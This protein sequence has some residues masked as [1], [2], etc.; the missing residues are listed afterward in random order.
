MHTING[1]T[2]EGKNYSCMFDASE[3]HSNVSPNGQYYFQC[4]VLEA[5]RR[6]DDQPA[7]LIFDMDDKLVYA[8]PMAAFGYYDDTVHELLN[9]LSFLSAEKTI[10][11]IDLFTLPFGTKIKV[12]WHDSRHHKPN[13][14]Y[15]GVIYGHMIGWEDGLSDEQGIIME[16]IHDGCCKVYLI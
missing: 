11:A 14:T 9:K 16:S 4:G 6:S 8:E 15:K 7:T 5:D 1:G 12:V 3:K 13:E 10:E 2:F